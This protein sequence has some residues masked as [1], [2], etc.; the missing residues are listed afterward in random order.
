VGSARLTCGQ[1]LRQEAYAQ[2]SLK[3]EHLTVFRM[4]IREKVTIYCHWI[5]G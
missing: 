5:M 3:R 2:L 1:L 4:L